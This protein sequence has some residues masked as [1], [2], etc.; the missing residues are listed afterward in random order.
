MHWT[1]YMCVILYM[2]W[3]PSDSVMKD[4]VFKKCSAGYM[5]IDK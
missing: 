4:E 5:Y 3:L 1:I 2:Q